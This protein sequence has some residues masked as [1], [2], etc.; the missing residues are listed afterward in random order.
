[1]GIILI[2]WHWTSAFLGLA[3]MGLIYADTFK[4]DQYCINKFG[5][6]YKRYMEKVP[7]V[8]FVAG[9]IGHIQSE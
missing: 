6:E 4:A 7:R 5:D 3:S 9:I 1:M 8:N 2:A